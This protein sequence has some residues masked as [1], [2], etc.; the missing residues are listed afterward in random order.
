MEV[1][2][3]IYNK[4][5]NKGEKWTM[6]LKGQS[7]IL[8]LVVLL[9]VF[10]SCTVAFA[11]V[12][13]SAASDAG[14]QLN[15]TKEYLENQ[16]VAQQIAEEKTKTKDK[17]EDKTQKSNEAEETD[18]KFIV[19][20]IIIKKSV[21]INNQEIQD[22]TNKYVGKKVA[23]KDLYNVVAEIN[24]LYNKKGYFTCRAFLP[25]QTIKKGVVNIELIEGKT[26]NIIVEGNKSTNSEYITDRLHLK[27]DDVDNIHVLNKDLLW[28]NANNDA[29][30][31]ISLQAGEMPGTTDYVI[32]TVEPQRSTFTTYVDN[33]GY[34]SSGL[35][36]EGLFYTNKSLTGKR[37]ILNISTIFSQGTKA[38]SSFYSMPV[39]RS[40]TRLIAQYSANSVHVISGAMKDMN[41][42]GHSNSYGLSV[43]QPLA[44][45]ENLKTQA[46]LEY[47]HQNS[48]TDFTGI[49]WVDD[50]INDYT[51]SF[52]MTNYGK[53]YVLYQK[54]SYRMGRWENIDGAE[55]NFGKY[56]V[57]LFY[58]KAYQSGQMLS[59]R[60]DGQWS[61]ANYMP[62]A[63][64]FY[65]GG[66]YSVRGYKESFLSG[67]HGYSSSLEYSVP[68]GKST[69][70]FSFIDYGAVYGESALD[71]HV[72][73]SSGIGVKTTIAKKIYANVSLG[74]PFRKEIN[75]TEVSKVRIHFMLN[76]Q[77]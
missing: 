52:S 27:H 3:G 6:I 69:A 74:V 9:S 61:S 64:Q 68:L 47:S 17:V 4:I 57:N 45:T 25:V 28:F 42:R 21:V 38:V 1:F 55:R 67:D 20:A 71:D 34:D 15:R 26:G 58:Q 43:V 59:A 14:V 33:A 54:H 12:Q 5:N 10:S 8:T 48:K 29:Q 41:V 75:G 7:K 66:M 32:S 51:A 76:G 31:H 36:R 11:A 19:N 53:S 44:V 49:H 39:G 13:P 70:I 73:I 62:S 22:I 30:L 18:I 2:W 16:R 65:I 63:E 35:W 23:I 24:A 60:V 40:G 50:T 56:Q 72:L 37:D 46:A 77:F